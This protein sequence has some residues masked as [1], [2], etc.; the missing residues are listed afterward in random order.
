MLNCLTF[1]VMMVSTVLQK[2]SRLAWMIS[3]VKRIQGEKRH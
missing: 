1:R 2:F 3:V